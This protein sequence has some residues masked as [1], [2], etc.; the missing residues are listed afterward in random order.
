MDSHVYIIPKKPKKTNIAQ[1][2]YEI[3]DNSSIC[4]LE[5]TEKELK[6]EELCGTLWKFY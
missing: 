1:Y 4:S 3:E 2:M 5:E 6:K